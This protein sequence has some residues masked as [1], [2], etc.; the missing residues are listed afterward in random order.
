MK[1]NFSVVISHKCLLT[2]RY[3]DGY[4]K[5]SKIERSGKKVGEF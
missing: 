4:M 5:N 1:P 2:A 3:L